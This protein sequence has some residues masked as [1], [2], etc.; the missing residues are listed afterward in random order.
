MEPQSD[1]L[2]IS[3]YIKNIRFVSR[4][5]ESFN[6]TAGNTAILFKNTTSNAAG[7]RS[8]KPGMQAYD[9]IV[10]ELRGI[11]YINILYE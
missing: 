9:L 1:F 7:K 11:V 8:N 3:M 4:V 2:S 6:K 10:M 5:P